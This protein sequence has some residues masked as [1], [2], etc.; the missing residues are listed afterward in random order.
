MVFRFFFGGVLVWL[1]IPHEPD[2]GFGRPGPSGDSSFIE[3]VCAFDTA[4]V[5]FAKRLEAGV[6][7]AP[8][9]M[10]SHRRFPAAPAPRACHL[11]N[12]HP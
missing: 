8:E 1:L 3:I 11:V 7:D 6:K 9:S 12:R 10:P 4:V 2:I 5:N